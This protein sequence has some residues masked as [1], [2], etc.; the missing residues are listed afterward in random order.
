MIDAEI[1]K[2]A[3]ITEAE[4]TVL[5]RSVFASSDGKKLIEALCKYRHPMM[6]R[7]QT[8]DPIKAADLDGQL[9]VI[10]FLHRNA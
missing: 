5:C 10:T 1:A 8:S 7:F 9:K 4:L 6:P 3:G 2:K